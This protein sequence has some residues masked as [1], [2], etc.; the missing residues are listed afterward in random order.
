M[1][2]NV[3]TKRIHAGQ[4]MVYYNVE[5]Y[6]MAEFRELGYDS[7]YIANAIRYSGHKHKFQFNMTQLN[8]LL[9]IAYGVRLVSHRERLVKEHP[10][11]WPYGP[12]FPR[13][14][15]HVKLSDL[16]TSNEYDALSDDIK[17]LID[18]VVL[19]FGKYNAGQ[20]S[21]WS[22]QHGSPWEKA[23]SRSDGKW[24]EKLDDEDIYDFFY[25]FIKADQGGLDG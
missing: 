20:L 21:S 18:S 10:A 3:F 13:V 19:T 2:N 5:G 22:H 9:Y 14:R 25:T 11:A 23:L 12:V 4:S 7:V 6:G 17:G 8:K 16:I 1:I 24:N 15:N